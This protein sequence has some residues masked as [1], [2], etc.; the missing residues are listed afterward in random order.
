M[1][2]SVKHQTLDFG[3]A[4]DLTVREIEPR[5]RLWADSVEP[6]WDS[7][8]LCPSPALLLSLS[9]KTNEDKLL[10]IRLSV[11]EPSL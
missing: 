8:S 9:L 10:N 4:H 6:T 3:S 5:V 1:A 7:L 11:P 2:Q